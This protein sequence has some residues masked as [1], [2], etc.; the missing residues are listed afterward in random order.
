MPGDLHS[1]V[2]PGMTTPVIVNSSQTCGPEIPSSRN[3]WTLE[4]DGLANG[5]TPGKSRSREH[6]YN[7]E[8][9]P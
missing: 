1:R 2:R 8:S 3:G 9:S 5:T 6:C 7:Q 4:K